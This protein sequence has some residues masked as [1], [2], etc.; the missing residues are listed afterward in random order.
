MPMMTNL[1]CFIKA[2]LNEY[3]YQHA[4]NEH[5]QTRVVVNWKR[6]S[7]AQKGRKYSDTTKH[8]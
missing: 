3:F 5:G 4:E 8:A 7:S 2:R 6:V 1:R